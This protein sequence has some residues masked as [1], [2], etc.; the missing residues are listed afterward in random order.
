MI[1]EY[2][3]FNF[4]M[5]LLSFFIYLLL[6]YIVCGIFCCRIALPC[7]TFGFMYF[8]LLVL[9]YCSFVDYMWVLDHFILCYVILS[10]VYLTLSS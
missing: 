3:S 10:Y 2:I 4:A 6:H 9:L 1:V 7:I 8:I 5:L